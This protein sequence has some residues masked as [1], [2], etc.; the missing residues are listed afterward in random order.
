[1]TVIELVSWLPLASMLAFIMVIPVLSEE[2]PD[3]PDLREARVR[4]KRD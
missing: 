2:L 4:T 3:H 1:M